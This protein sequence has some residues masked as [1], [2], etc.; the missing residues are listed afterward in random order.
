MTV[1]KEKL[2]QMVL[3]A[4]VNGQLLD[5]HFRYMA[6]RMKASKVPTKIVGPDPKTIE[7]YR[8]RCNENN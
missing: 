5:G 1:D 4:L 7:A 2:R 8:R 6:H 3:S